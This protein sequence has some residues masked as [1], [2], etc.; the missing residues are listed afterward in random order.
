MPH[1]TSDSAYGIWSLNEVRDAVR[2]DNW[3]VVVSTTPPTITGYDFDAGVRDDTNYPTTHTGT[4]NIPS[5]SPLA[6]FIVNRARTDGVS[7]TASFTVDG[8]TCNQYDF[9]SFNNNTT[10]VYYLE[11]PPSGS[12]SF[13]SVDTGSASVGVAVIGLSDLSIPSVSSNVFTPANT[14][15]VGLQTILSLSANT[16]QLI[17]CIAPADN[18]VSESSSTN[19]PNSLFSPVAQASTGNIPRNFIHCSSSIFTSS[20]TYSVNYD[21]TNSGESKDNQ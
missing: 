4:I 1:P 3:P 21:V 5:S 7:A 16:G 10:R 14:D 6:V 17:Y 15:A 2:G 12:V 9:V 19:S 13:T 18:N 20:Q 8:N 11:N